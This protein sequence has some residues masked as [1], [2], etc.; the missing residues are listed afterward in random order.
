MNTVE[1]L[2]ESA[3]ERLDKSNN[4]ADLVGNRM[5]FPMLIHYCG[6]KDGEMREHLKETFYRIWPQTSDNIVF[7]HS[8]SHKANNDQAFY[9]EKSDGATDCLTNVQIQNWVDEVRSRRGIFASMMKWCIYNIIDTSE[10]TN[11][12]EFKAKYDLVESLKNIV[13]GGVST[14]LIVLLDESTSKKEIARAIRTELATHNQYDGVIVISNR[15]IKCELYS[16][17][18]LFNIVAGI[19]VL[20]NNDAVASSDDDEYEKRFACLFGNR[21]HTLSY[22]FLKR[23]NMKIGMQIFNVLIENVYNQEIVRHETI[24]EDNLAK[25]IGIENGR[26]AHIENK[27]KDLEVKFPEDLCSSL[28]FKRVP[29]NELALSSIPYSEFSALLYDGVFESFLKSY[30]DKYVIKGTQIDAILNEYDAEIRAKVTASEYRDITDDN[31]DN[32]INLIEIREPNKGLTVADYFKNCVKYYITKCFI[33]P[34]LRQLLLSLR[35]QSIET[36]EA[37]NRF[38]IEFQRIMPIEGFSDLGSVYLNIAE[39]YVNS[40]AGEEKQK[41]LIAPGKNYN[42][43]TNDLMKMFDNILTLNANVF[44]QSFID[45]WETRLNLAGEEIY[46]RIQATFESDFDQKLFLFGNFQRNHIPLEVYMF[47]TTDASGQAETGLYKHLRAAMSSSAS[48]QF[49]NTGCDDIVEAFRFI[50]CT[51]NKLLL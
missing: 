27:L 24:S 16:F 10:M 18:E 32:I 29:N 13:D 39:N 20:S 8:H 40:P 17:D 11:V 47:H 38:R 4:S 30:C 22:S 9:G 14:M 48:V 44:S 7:I 19:I 12:H 2:V 1:K 51:G 45:E 3:K 15:T 36:L 31:I 50:D 35:D 25:I 37:F 34:K 43:F 41:K 6:S 33:L 21:T 23:P 5:H 28:P 46:K 26:I 49:V 42:E